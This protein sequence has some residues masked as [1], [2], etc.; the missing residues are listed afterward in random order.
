MASDIKRMCKWDKDTLKKN[1]DEFQEDVAKAN[2]ACLKC[3]RV[4]A[5]K[6]KLCKPKKL[7]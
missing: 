2:F 4:A 1:F 6:Q 7:K 5:T 3:A